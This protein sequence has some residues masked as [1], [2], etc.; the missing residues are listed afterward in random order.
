MA[1][2]RLKSS[3]SGYSAELDE[4]ERA[5]RDEIMA[6]QTRR[7]AWSLKHAHDN[8]AH[9]KKAFD[10]AGVH[11][12]D[13]KQLSDLAKFP[14]TV[15]TDLR[16]NYPFNRFAVPR[17][18]L[19]R[20]H[21]SSGTTGK[22]IVVGYTRADIDTWS[23]VMARS[24]RAAGGRTGMIMHNAYGYGLFT[25]GLGAH[26]GAERLGCPVGPGSGGPTGREGARR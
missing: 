10:T 19:V 15:K 23:D 18:K 17:E 12:S 24:I 20:V 1:M 6:L 14:F 3:G 13:F 5:S 25:G 2:A 11:P 22:P 8:V 21:A 26:Y 7:L 9:Y 4:A 16:A